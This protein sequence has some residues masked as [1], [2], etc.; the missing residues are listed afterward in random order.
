MAN[1]GVE[2]EIFYG[3]AW[4][5]VT[6]YDRD[7]VTISRGAGAEGQDAPPTAVALTLEG[8]INPKDP[9]G[10]LYGAAGRNTPMRVTADG[11]VRAVVE[12]A[13][14][15]PGRS[16]GVTRVDE[17]TRLEGS[18]VLRRLG[19]AS[20]RA[21]LRS[22]AW[23]TL[24]A[25]ANDAD[26]IAY[27]PVEEASG[28]TSIYTPYTEQT[29][30]GIV[31]PVSL[32]ADEASASS[33]R[34]ATLGAG[35]AVY[36]FPPVYTAG[37][38]TKIIGLFRVPAAGLP[39]PSTI[40][41]IWVTGGSL[42]HFDLVWTSGNGLQLRVW[43]VNTLI[44]TWGPFAWDPW[45]GQGAEF[46]MSLEFTQ[47]GA[48]L[49]LLQLMLRVDNGLTSLPTTTVAGQTMGRVTAITIGYTDSSGLSFGQIA[50]A[51]E[52]GAFANYISPVNGS[53]GTQGFSGEVAGRRFLRLADE[54]NVPCTVIG[55]PDDTQPM[56]P[57]PTGPIMDLLRECVRTDDAM[58]FETR[59]ALE[60][61]MRTGRDRY[62]QPAALAL[63]F[64]G[65]EIAP[66]LAPVLDDKG[67]RNDVTIKR[68]DGGTAQAV[69][70]AGPLNI[71][72]PVD[73]PDGVGRYDVSIDVNTSADAVL[74]NL[75]S[76]HLHV[77]TWD[78]A[79]YPSV[80][81]DLD[82]APA[83]IAAVNA[84]EIGDRITIENL[85]AKW[86]PN[87]ANLLVRGIQ[88][89]FPSGAG[90]FRRTVTFVTVPAGPY[91]I[92]IVGAANG[93]VDLRGQAVDTD[94][95]MLGGAGATLTSTSLTVV[96]TGGVRW[97]T[98]SNDWNTA[99]HGTCEFGGGLFIVIGGEVMRISN[100]TGAASPQTVTVVRAIN[101]VSKTHPA[102]SAVHVYRPARAGL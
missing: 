67:T 7:G 97:T 48:N 87:D 36:F 24:T 27:W 46:F 78:E 34:L 52:T 6:A 77:G 15:A 66:P 96:S 93:S 16:L 76:W 70:T 10:P 17:W 72:P 19:R 73:D 14:W 4:E 69:Q 91:E 5:S 71:N 47:N 64:A 37:N 88:E 28:A 20:S 56:G 94:L 45:I 11:S 83:L 74:P 80:V 31:A 51:R 1:H 98:R 61:V 81:V 40:M 62:N 26:R 29:T 13:S 63:D 41:R 79:R 25:P 21:P 35:G 60:L 85:P 90:D 53:L 18:G 2:A 86:Q 39:D 49:D 102:G 33:E 12:A 65:E 50:V 75:A 84:V 32:G 54:E 95:S 3:G 99:L 58:M 30:P 38:E 55:D 101:G 23:R 57:Q 42:T 82:S 44:T 59:D 92:G 22:P 43:S 89:D 68:R 9:T 100:V 8:T